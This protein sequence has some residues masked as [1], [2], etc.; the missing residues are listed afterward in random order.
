MIELIPDLI[1]F[2]SG[3]PCLRESSHAVFAAHEFLVM[4]GR[5]MKLKK[6]CQIGLAQ[7]QMENL[8]KRALYAAWLN[9]PLVDCMG[10]K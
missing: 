9:I 5:N 8:V 3:Y 10:R 2:S 7:N 6:L 4:L 1:A